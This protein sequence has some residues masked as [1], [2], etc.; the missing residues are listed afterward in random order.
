MSSDYC[1]VDRCRLCRQVSD[2]IIQSADVIVIIFELNGGLLFANNYALQVTGYSF[3]ELSG[4]NWR[5]KIL[6]R[7]DSERLMSVYE[8]L[9]YTEK[10]AQLTFPVLTKDGGE[11]YVDCRCSL[12][13]SEGAPDAVM[14][15]CRNVTRSIMLESSLREK[16]SM[17]E[18]LTRSLERSVIK[19]IEERRAQE[20]A[21]AEHT[22]LAAIENM[23][24]ALAHQWRQPLT[25]AGIIIQ[26][27][28]DTYEEGDMNEE[29]MREFCDTALEQIMYLSRTIDDFRNYFRPSYEEEY[30][31]IGEILGEVFHIFSPK[32]YSDF[33]TYS[34]NGI[35][36]EPSDFTKTPD[37]VERLKGRDYLA[38]GYKSHFKQAV[39]N[40][41]QNSYESIQERRETEPGFI[42]RIDIGVVRENTDIRMIISDNGVGIPEGQMERI[43]EPY[44]TTKHM[45]RG[46]G[47]GLYISRVLLE[48]Y[49]DGNITAENR[50]EGASVT[51]VLKG[52]EL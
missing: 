11:I 39:T 4:D 36:C 16:N 18:E 45:G 50:D 3:D 41:V 6:N 47:M 13:R 48:N 31:T 15:V 44:F 17:L 21:F 26:D 9:R 43:F 37:S 32:I 38:K 52:A 33:I 40:M 42:G 49:M 14:G 5:E 30:F 24:N 2:G 29:L 12:I 7:K 28:Q 25:A 23:I 22:K 1:N 34:V 20:L 27:L 35:E 8:E 51:I 19:G 10:S 46:T